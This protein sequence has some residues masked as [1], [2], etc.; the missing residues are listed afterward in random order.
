MGIGRFQVSC[1]Y[2]PDLPENVVVNTFYLRDN[3]PNEFPGTTDWGKLCDDA[4]AAWQASWYGASPLKEIT[5]K[6]YNAEAA[7]PNFPIHTK[8][9][10]PGGNKILPNWPPQIAMCLSYKGGPLPHQ[11]G[12][13][14]LAPW[15]TAAYNAAGVMN[16]R[17]S[18]AMRT[19]ALDLATA[20]AGL[21]GVD[22]DWGV[23]SPSKRLFTP[24]TQ[25]WVDDSYDTQR[26]RNWKS[27]A[28]STRSFS[29]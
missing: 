8:V 18:D 14:Y 5:V 28:R 9:L 1:G 19:F 6:V 11:R 3:V 12:R 29:E 20:L 4:A 27:T 13:M 17:P 26:R 22:I 21:G 23:W 16:T 24:T 25:A 10:N 15:L 2:Q 7:P